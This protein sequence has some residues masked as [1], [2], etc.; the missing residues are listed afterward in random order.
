[1][2]LKLI[3]DHGDRGSGLGLARHPERLGAGA[4]QRHLRAGHG[5]L[6]PTVLADARHERGDHRLNR[7]R[8]VGGLWRF[9]SPS[10]R[11]SGTSTRPPSIRASSSRRPDPATLTGVAVLT[12]SPGSLF[13]GHLLLRL[14]ELL[15]DSGSD[16]PHPGGRHRRGQRRHAEPFRR[17][18]AGVRTQRRSLR[19][20]RPQDGGRNRH[21][22][23]HMPEWLHGHGFFPGACPSAPRPL[24]RSPSPIDVP[25]SGAGQQWSIAFT[26]LDGKF[27]GGPADV[28]VDAFVCFSLGC[29]IPH[30]DQSLI[31]RGAKDERPVTGIT[32]HAQYGSKE[33][34][35]EAAGLSE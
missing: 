10:P 26:P 21:R 19:P 31:L 15:G 5:D 27:K 1:M 4:A 20:V 11:R 33:E 3:L 30:A 13:G 35:L 32:L 8:S 29:L 25:C 24:K 28:S 17:D 14:C 9:G 18:D 16:L 6:L 23:A 7:R 2:K 34:A 12:G 22:H